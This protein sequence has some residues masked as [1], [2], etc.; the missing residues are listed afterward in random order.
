M[1][2]QELEGRIKHLSEVLEQYELDCYIVTSE[3]GIWCL[4]NV[5]YQPEKRR[6]FTVVTADMRP[7]LVVPKLEEE[8]LRKVMVN[9]DIVSYWEYPS[10][11]GQNWYD[12]F[13]GVLSGRMR[14]GVKRSVK[15]EI[16]E[17]ISGG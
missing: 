2:K 16:R 5:A 9:C 12:V 10:P 8:H 15:A 3:D 1:L 13:E 14:I 6:F 17:C 11:S 4:T 7:C